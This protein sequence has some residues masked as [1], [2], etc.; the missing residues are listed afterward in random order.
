MNT[1]IKISEESVVPKK[2]DDLG[3]ALLSQ[4]KDIL[5]RVGYNRLTIREVASSCGVAVGTVYN[6]YSSKDVLIACIML[7]DWVAALKS[8]ENRS[9]QAANA[10]DGLHAVYDAIAAFSRQYADAWAQYSARGNAASMIR[11]RHR[12]LID[13]L[14]AVIEPLLVRFGA[15]FHESLPPFLAETLL[16]ASID[17]T[18]RFDELLPILNKLLQ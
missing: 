8:M 2:I 13:Q 9:E 10:V 18:A 1:F 14:C 7:E 11:A 12:Q 3:N 4:A 15:L 16:A 6:Y 5:M 17:P